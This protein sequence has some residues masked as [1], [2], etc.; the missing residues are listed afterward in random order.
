MKLPLFGDE[1][2]RY[3]R[4][5]HKQM[6]KSMRSDP[7]AV[8]SLY[9][10]IGCIVGFHPDVEKRESFCSRY[11][12]ELFDALNALL[13]AEKVSSESIFNICDRFSG[14]EYI[15]KMSVKMAN[16]YADLI[17]QM[18]KTLP[19]E[20]SDSYFTRCLE[21]AVPYNG[22]SGTS[23]LPNAQ[24][25]EVLCAA[26]SNFVRGISDDREHFKSS[27]YLLRYLDSYKDILTD[28][29][30]NHSLE[31]V[32]GFDSVFANKSIVSLVLGLQKL[33]PD[34]AAVQIEAIIQTQFS[35][36]L[37]QAYKTND[38]EVKKQLAECVQ[39]LSD[40][41]LTLDE[42]SVSI[43]DT[44]T[45]RL[46]EGAELS[47]MVVCFNTVA[48]ANDKKDYVTLSRLNIRDDFCRLKEAEVVVTINNDFKAA[49]VE[50]YQDS[51][52]ALAKKLMINAPRIGH[53]T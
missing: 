44:E 45:V 49:L 4:S 28:D 5:I 43:L 41:G 26:I 20:T 6:K 50:Q 23:K 22:V 7:G 16:S 13:L 53:I 31:V 17:T 29:F 42:P 9:W 35:Q 34:E 40:N 48:K 8:Y 14:L 39:L 15:N 10:N 24:T 12:V 19:I 3:W 27:E 30:Y 52:A 2:D 33:V 37:A 38:D 47:A 1:T 51:G 21:I 36:A 11:G 18:S 25:N 32:R 46:P